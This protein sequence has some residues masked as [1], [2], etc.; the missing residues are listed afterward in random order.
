MRQPRSALAAEQ[1][2]V[3]QGMTS[4]PSAMA[5]SCGRAAE[6]RGPAAAA[7]GTA[8]TRGFRLG[9]RALAAPV[10]QHGA[11]CPPHWQLWALPSPG[12]PAQL[13]LDAAPAPNAPPLL[14]AARRAR[15]ALAL[16]LALALPPS[17]RRAAHRRR[18]GEGAPRPWLPHPPRAQQSGGRGHAPAARCMDKWPQEH[19][20]GLPVGGHEGQA[21]RCR[22]CGPERRVQSPPARGAGH[23]PPAQ[24]DCTGVHALPCTCCGRVQCGAWCIEPEAASSAAELLPPCRSSS[25]TTRRAPSAACSRGA[26]SCASS[27]RRILPTG[28]TRPRAPPAAARTATRPR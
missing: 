12:A 28:R 22:F 27:R 20:G 18:L 3:L 1:A 5:S 6:A 21:N 7:R 19:R 11:H 13:L 25:T 16:A 24:G 10:S 17:P 8:H 26:A 9:A 14:I 15:L 2:N 23:A 4:L